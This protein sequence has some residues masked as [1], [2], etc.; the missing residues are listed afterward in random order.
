MKSHARIVHPRRKIR[1]LTTNE[2]FAIDGSISVLPIELIMTRVPNIIIGIPPINFEISSPS[3][4][5]FV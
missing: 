3:L 1:I 2:S 4:S 5:L